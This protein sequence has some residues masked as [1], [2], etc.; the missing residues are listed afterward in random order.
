MRF[1]GWLAIYIA[2]MALVLV[3]TGWDF[4]RVK[5]ADITLALVTA[6]SGIWFLV[7]YDYIKAQEKDEDLREIWR[8][9]NRLVED[10]EKL[11]EKRGI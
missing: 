1:V 7:G 8:K 10:H 4:S 3:V 9:Y 5:L 2:V 6:W 11:K